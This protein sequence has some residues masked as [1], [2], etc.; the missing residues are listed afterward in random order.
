MFVHHLETVARSLPSCSANHLQVRFFS[1][2]ITLIRF[3]SLFS[4]IAYTICG[5]KITLFYLE[6]I[7][8]LKESDEIR[9]TMLCFY[10]HCNPNSSNNEFVLAL[11]LPIFDDFL[12]LLSMCKRNLQMP[13]SENCPCFPL[14]FKLIMQQMCQ[15]SK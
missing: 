15:R 11:F 3:K 2:S 14:E 8:F 7:L 6:S 12:Y 5:C 13:K 9:E 1:T 4:S 10:Q